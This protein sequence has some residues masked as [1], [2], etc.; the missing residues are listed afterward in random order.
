MLKELEAHRREQYVSFF[1][2][3][4][5]HDALG[6]KEPALAALRR[7]Y[8]D[9]A[10]EFGLIDQYPRVQDDC[11]GAGISNHHAA[12]RTLTPP[13]VPFCPSCWQVRCVSGMK[14]AVGQ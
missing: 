8:E 9:R 11:V 13:A 12:G 6:E 2:T 10:V 4:L 3:A 1:G 7:A 5:I 14:V